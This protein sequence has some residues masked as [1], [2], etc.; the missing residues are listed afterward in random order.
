MAIF[1]FVAGMVIG[2][3]VTYAALTP[4]YEQP[5]YGQEQ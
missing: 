5:W 2:M 4:D 1:T 3:A